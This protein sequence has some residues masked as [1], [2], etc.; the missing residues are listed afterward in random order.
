[1]HELRSLSDP[2]VAPRRG[3]SG[4]TLEQPPPLPLHAQS[5]ASAEG[6]WWSRVAR[7]TGVAGS[8]LHVQLATT[9]ASSSLP[10]GISGRRFTVILDAATHQVDMY[11][12]VVAPDFFNDLSDRCGR[13]YV[14]TPSSGTRCGSATHLYVVRMVVVVPGEISGLMLGAGGWWHWGLSICDVCKNKNRV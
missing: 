14:T 13:K 6:C 12:E 2:R 8:H 5:P 1:M 9:G 3:G 7:H 4:E 10:G 11:A